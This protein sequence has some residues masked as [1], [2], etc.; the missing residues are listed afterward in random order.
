MGE[1]LRIVGVVMVRLVRWGVAWVSK[2]IFSGV[3]FVVVDFEALGE[4]DAKS[5]GIRYQ[6]FP[7]TGKVYLVHGSSLCSVGLF[8]SKEI[9]KIFC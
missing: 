4:V 3:I 7:F 5:L 2:R 1:G 8:R 6:R 9:L